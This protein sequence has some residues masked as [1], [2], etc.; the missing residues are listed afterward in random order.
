MY[1]EL[2][3]KFTYPISA[4]EKRMIEKLKT[5]ICHKDLNLHI[6]LLHYKDDLANNF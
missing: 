5:L 3:L 6:S 4:C 1:K 2:L